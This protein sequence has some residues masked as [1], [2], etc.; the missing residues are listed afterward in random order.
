MTRT[1]SRVVVAVDT[2]DL[3]VA[4]GLAG[5]CKAA[6]AIKLGLEFFSAQGPSGVQKVTETGAPLFLDLKLHDI[7]N[8][9]VGALR[10]LRPLAPAMLTIHAAGGRAM[11]EAA[12]A[13]AETY[14]APPA[15]LG[16]TALTSLDADDLASTGIGGTMSDQVVRLA[17]LACASGLAGVVCAPTEAERVRRETGPG[18]LIVTPG[19]RPAASA[20]QD[21]KR[22]ATPANAIAAGADLLVIG[23]PVT[24]SEDPARALDAIDAELGGVAG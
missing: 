5:S 1:R 3:D 9:V 7:P 10:S 6:A 8:T 12:R 11:L 15:L 20:A 16:V 4:L 17:V 23:R 13:A 22:I 19:I 18:F 2:P 14:S 21:Q 24:G